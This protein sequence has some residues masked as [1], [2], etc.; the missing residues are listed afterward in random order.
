MKETDRMYVRTVVC[1]SLF[2]FFRLLNYACQSQVG[3]PTAEALL[4]NEIQW[5][6]SVRDQLLKTGM[7]GDG[8]GP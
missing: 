8:A 5:L 6:K 3:V 4:N 2:V 1:I 7:A